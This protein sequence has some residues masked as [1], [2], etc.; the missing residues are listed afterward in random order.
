MTNFAS[1]KFNKIGIIQKKG[2]IPFKFRTNFE[3]LAND[4]SEDPDAVQLS[5]S[6]FRDY[7]RPSTPGSL[8]VPSIAV[9]GKRRT[10]LIATME[11]DIEDWNIKIKIGGLG[12]MAQ[13]LHSNFAFKINSNFIQVD[14]EKP[15]TSGLDMG[16]ALCWRG[17]LPHRSAS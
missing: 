9:P 16:G 8:I 17:G 11:Y 1:V 2:L 6:E 7:S 3:K 10:V 14:G 5:E 12:V 4:E 13:Y 15:F